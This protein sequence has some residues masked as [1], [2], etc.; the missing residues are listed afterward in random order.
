MVADEVRKLAE[1]SSKSTREIAMLIA[2]VHK[3]TQEAVSAAQQGAGEVESGFRLAEEAGNALEK[4]LAAA[5]AA[6]V[7]S[8]QITAAVHQ[9]EKAAQQVVALSTP[10]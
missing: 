4:I 5:K 8:G 6:S 7:Q 1:R 2:H 3:G 9:M 10:T